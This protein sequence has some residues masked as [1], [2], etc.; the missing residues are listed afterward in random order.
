MIHIGRSF[1]FIGLGPGLF[2]IYAAFKKERHFAISLLLIFVMQMLFFASY[3]VLDKQT[4]F[5]PA[6]LIWTIWFALGVQ[7]LISWME[8][9]PHSGANIVT[10]R[11][12]QI[13]L[14]IMVIFSLIVNFK[15][16]DQ[17]DNFSTQKIALSIMESLPPNATV[18]GYWDTI[19]AIQYYQLVEHLRPDLETVNRFLIGPGQFSDFVN[20]K[21]QNNLLFFAYKPPDLPSGLE[22]EKEDKV[23]HVIKN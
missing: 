11:L 4:M 20:I 15:L 1:W 9:T 5:L 12:I 7:F 19:P 17:S 14:V 3:R 10:I 8:R 22:I 18:I 21:S 16:V 13:L 2:G 23:F 6:D